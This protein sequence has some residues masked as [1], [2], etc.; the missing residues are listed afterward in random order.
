[1]DAWLKSAQGDAW[2]W[3]GELR[4]FGAHRRNSGKAAFVVQFRVGRGRLAKRRRVV[5]G[6]YPVMTPEQAR[7]QAVVHIGAGWKGC[8]PI[9]ENRARQ[10]AQARQRDTF[11]GLAEA[12][13]AARRSHLK[14]RSADQ[15]QSIWRRLILPDLGPKA[16]SEVRRRD[17]A[18]LMDRAEVSV[19]SSAADRIHEQLVIFF[20]WYAERDDDFASP[21]IRTMKRHRKGTG[22]RPMTDDELRQFWQACLHAGVAGAAGRL[23]LLSAARRNETTAAV[24]P[25][26][27]ETG[28]WTI[29]SARYKTN[30]DHVVP[31]SDAAQAVVAELART[32]PYLF[33]TTENAPDPWSLWKAIVDAG[34]PDGEGLSWHSLRKTARTLMSR[35]GVRADH[36]ERALGHVQG[37]VERAYDKHSYLP[38]KRA[39]FDIL[40]VEV[41]RV[42]DG[43]QVSNVV[44]L[45]RSA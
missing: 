22:A 42:V 13:Y 35:A 16:I 30:K 45:V 39:A 19:G 38:E 18:E 41:E 27:S 8:D 2:L 11:N 43:R 26:I 6:E 44:P 25:E 40:A 20:R 1:M 36:A 14:G 21:L 15:Y 9:A 10:A 3:C 7:E 32:S 28:V 5:L 17:I 33:G 34:A 23:C 24:W 12:F 31:L 37:A 29:P 4:G